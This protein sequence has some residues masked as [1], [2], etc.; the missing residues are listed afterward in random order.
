MDYDL[1]KRLI[2][3]NFDESARGEWRAR[4]AAITTAVLS[5]LASLAPVLQVQDV[6]TLVAIPHAGRRVVLDVVLLQQASGVV[7]SH[8]TTWMIWPMPQRMHQTPNVDSNITHSMQIR[9]G[10]C[11]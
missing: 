8:R 3:L 10:T 2:I 1:L 11:P 4:R 9:R 7:A 5:V 6:L